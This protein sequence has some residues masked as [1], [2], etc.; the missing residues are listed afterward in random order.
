MTVLLQE[1]I[2]TAI[3]LQIATEGVK[4]NMAIENE[5]DINSMATEIAAIILLAIPLISMSTN[6]FEATLSSVGDVVSN[7][8][9]TLFTKNLEDNMRVIMDRAIEA[10]SNNLNGLI[11][12][13][14]FKFNPVSVNEA[15]SQYNKVP[16]IDGTGTGAILASIL[17]LS[18]L[19]KE[20]EK[21]KGALRLARLNGLTNKEAADLITGTRDRNLRD[22]K[23]FVMARSYN[24]SMRTLVQHALITSRFA[25]AGANGIEEYQWAS[26]LDSSTSMTCQ[27]LDGKIF[28][29]GQG[30]RPPAHFG[31]RSTIIML[32]PSRLNTN[33][34]E[35]KR[36][37][38]YD[39]LSDQS[40]RTQNLALGK[41]RADIFRSGKLSNEEF[42]E[43]NLNSNFIP[44]TLE[45]MKLINPN[46]FSN[47]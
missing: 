39:W 40:A 23:A 33:G 26:V 38:Y 22:G 2:D 1:Q 31:C 37:S 12:D 44:I 20:S 45:Q 25:V 6:E 43:L 13:P 34:I 35:G 3:S 47:I 46:I 21:I 30:P 8:H 15:Y 14:S 9:N 5:E 18:L 7:Y 17:L 29:I 42:V 28:K 11:D 16:M 32:I 36:V 24:K 27:G 19:T 4:E 10:E 41:K